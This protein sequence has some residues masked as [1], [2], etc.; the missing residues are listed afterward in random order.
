MLDAKTPAPV[1]ATPKPT[2]SFAETMANLTKPKESVPSK[3]EDARPPESLEEKAKRLRKEERRKLHVT[4]K[5]DESLVETRI[6]VHDPEEE[7]GH[8]ESMVR[9]VGDIRGEGQMLKMHRDLE[10]T[11]DEEDGNSGEETLA[12]WVLPTRESIC[13]MH[14]SLLTDL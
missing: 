5:P 6:F 12:P 1:A 4:F 9:D 8:E 7:M 10:V 3:S 14:C 11:D 13:S 2:F